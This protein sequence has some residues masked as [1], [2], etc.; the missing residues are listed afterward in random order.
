MAG[1]K[2]SCDEFKNDESLFVF[3]QIRPYMSP[4][5]NSPLP[6]RTEIREREEINLEMDESNRMGP[7]SAALKTRPVAYT[8][9]VLED[10][11]EKILLADTLHAKIILRQFEK[12][13]N[14]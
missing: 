6:Q 12:R 2:S 1:L 8:R 14:I 13:S 7:K 9:N 4:S 5:I 10:L 3:T 11:S